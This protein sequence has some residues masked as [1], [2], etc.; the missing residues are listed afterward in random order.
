MRNGKPTVLIVAM[1][2]GDE[3]A[4]GEGALAYAKSLAQGKEGDA[5]SW[6]NVLIVPRA[7]PDGAD[8][9]TKALANGVDLNKDHFALSTPESRALAQ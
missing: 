3:P 7:N 6:I 9:F 2:H 4:S 5:L 8:A 1:Q